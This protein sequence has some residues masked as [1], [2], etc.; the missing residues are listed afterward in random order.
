MPTDLLGV[1]VAL[2]SIQGSLRMLQSYPEQYPSNGHWARVSATTDQLTHE[3]NQWMHTSQDAER[4]RHE[5]RQDTERRS[6]ER[7]QDADRD[8]TP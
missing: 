4:R 7:R 5:R 8:A 1:I 2:S 3:V 6:H